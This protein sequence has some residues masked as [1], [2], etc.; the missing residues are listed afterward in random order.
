VRGFKQRSRPRRTVLQQIQRNG[1]WCSPVGRDGNPLSPTFGECKPGNVC[2]THRQGDPGLQNLKATDVIG[3]NSMLVNME[4]D[5]PVSEELG[6][7][8]IV[9]R[10]G[11]VRRERLH[12][13]ARS[14]SGPAP[15][16]SGSARSARSWS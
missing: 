12:Q 4:I 16:S 11:N 7:S 1:R 3:G 5:F 15:G 8:G 10:H 14:G 13:P 2:N 6:L 9:F